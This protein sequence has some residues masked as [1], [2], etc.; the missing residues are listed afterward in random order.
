MAVT[1]NTSNYSLLSNCDSLTSGGTWTGGNARTIETDFYKFAGGTNSYDAFGKLQSSQSTTIREYLPVY[2]TL[3]DDFDERI[4]NA[5]VLQTTPLVHGENGDN[6]IFFDPVANVVVLQTGTQ[7]GDRVRRRSHIYHKYQTGVGTTIIF[8]TFLGDTGKVGVHRKIGFYDDNDGVYFHAMENDPRGLGVV[9]RHSVTGSVVEEY[10]HQDSWNIDRLD[11]SNDS[12]NISGH[13]LDPTKIQVMFI[14]FQWLGGGRIRF[15]FF[16]DG[17]SVVCH[18]INNANNIS[19][20]WS[21][22]GSL[23]LTM[24]QYNTV[25]GVIGNS[26]LYNVSAVV[27]CEGEYK[28]R[29]YLSSG[30]L[31][32]AVPVGPNANGQNYTFIGAVRPVKYLCYGDRFTWTGDVIMNHSHP[33]TKVPLTMTPGN[34]QSTGTN[35]V[36]EGFVAGD[37]IQIDGA[38]HNNRIIYIVDSISTTST[39]NDTL[40]LTTDSPPLYQDIATGVSIIAKKKTPNRA[41]GEIKDIMLMDVSGQNKPMLVELVKNVGLLGSTTGVLTTEGAITGG[42]GYSVGDICSTTG[43]TGEGCIVQVLSVSGGAVTSAHSI[44]A[45]NGYTI[46]DVLTLVGG[47]SD[48][49][50]TVD[51]IGEADFTWQDAY[52]GNMLDAA[53]PSTGVFGMTSQANTMYTTLMKDGYVQLD[54][55]E[56]FERNTELMYRHAELDD[57]PDNW[58]IRVKTFN[59]ADTAQLVFAISWLEIRA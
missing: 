48:A 40:N 5:G 58:A 17:V 27:R 47:N 20:V 54:L 4:W 16:L 49:T 59:D 52:S 25:G 46:N 31:P 38:N 56:H 43:G 44:V 10:Y 13:L 29:Q 36:T 50:V 24:E 22:T 39:T 7:N 42:S 2:D 45:G 57:E 51:S 3:P 33:G 21:R 8:S 55:R 9:L 23:P 15:G 1:V 37:Y 11:G 18:E 26:N 6:D 19:R 35:F 28:P 53:K 34:I 32:P 30:S 14:D 41:I 12:F